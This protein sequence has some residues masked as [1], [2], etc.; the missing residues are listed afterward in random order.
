[1]R[2]SDAVSRTRP[3]RR[4]GQAPIGQ[5]GDGRAE[6]DR[7]AVVDPNAKLVVSMEA[8]QHRPRVGSGQFTIHR[9]SEDVRPEPVL[10]EHCAAETHV[11]LD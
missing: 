2:P 10:I 6:V 1:M 8:E 4:V 3:N 11:V 9:A 5:V 7:A